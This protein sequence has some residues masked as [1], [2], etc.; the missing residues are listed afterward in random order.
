MTKPPQNSGVK[1][2]KEGERHGFPAK[3]KKIDIPKQKSF[4]LVIIRLKIH[5][6]LY[7][8]QSYFFIVELCGGLGI[9][10]EIW[11]GIPKKELKEIT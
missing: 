8:S 10:T 11:Y 6:L 2:R 1:K 3:E 4:S 5:L 7:D 9:L